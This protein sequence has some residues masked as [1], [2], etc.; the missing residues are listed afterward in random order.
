MSNKKTL[1][2]IPGNIMIRNIFPICESSINVLS[3]EDLVKLVEAPLLEACE[4][5][6][7]KNI[8]TLWSSA[9]KEN[10][11]HGGYANIQIDFDTLSD[12]NKEI[13][14]KFGKLSE[15]HGEKNKKSIELRFPLTKNTTV[16]EIRT[17]A[18]QVVS[19]FEKQKMTWAEKFTLD[20][21]AKAY[22]VPREELSPETFPEMYYDAKT[23]Y[24]YKSEEHFKKENNSS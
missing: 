19:Q 7:D 6:Y 16:G 10:L 8:K 11:E 24:L 5:L 9:N 20:D 22:R 1:E 4:E 23:G 21:L 14:L 15:L 3:R 17:M 13:A 18:H 12:K 2:R